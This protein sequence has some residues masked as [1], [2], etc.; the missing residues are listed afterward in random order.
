V[1]AFAWFRPRR[2]R[3]ALGDATIAEARERH[4]PLQGRA[5]SELADSGTLPIMFS[6]FGSAALVGLPAWAGV[7]DR[8]APGYYSTDGSSGCA[9]ACGASCG[10]D[11]GGGCGG[12]G[13][14]C[15]GCSSD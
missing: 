11:G 6:L 5:A 3:T 4:E 15:G 13:G 14:G 12:D 2:E 9:S 1:L 7:L 10:G 8:P